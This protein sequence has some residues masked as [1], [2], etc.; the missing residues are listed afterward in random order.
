MDNTKVISRSHQGHF[1]VKLTKILNSVMSLT[2]DE[3][4][5]REGVILPIRTQGTIRL[6]DSGAV[7]NATEFQH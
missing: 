1:K 3:W 6:E 7:R 5:Y 4:S 2:W